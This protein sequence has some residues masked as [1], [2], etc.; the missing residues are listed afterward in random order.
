MDPL[1]TVVT[2]ILGVGCVA[3]LGL[4]MLNPGGPASRTPSRA[5]REMDRAPRELPPTP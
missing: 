1:L 4:T 3:L 2:F 5:L